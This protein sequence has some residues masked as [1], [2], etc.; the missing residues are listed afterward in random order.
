MLNQV[1]IVGK[2][3]K[4]NELKEDVI[5]T[6]GVTRII[7]N[8]DTL[9]HDIDYIDIKISDTLKSNTLE[10]LR[11]DATVGV[12]ARL[13][14]KEIAVGENCINTVEVIAEK[15]TFINTSNRTK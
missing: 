6:L 4:I 2:V 8:P 10:Y 15:L 12:K 1:I 7:K 14:T 5:I 13:Q 3:I 11:V 9:E